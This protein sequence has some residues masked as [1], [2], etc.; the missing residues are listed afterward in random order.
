MDTLIQ[1]ILDPRKEE[2][3]GDVPFELRAYDTIFTF[4]LDILREDIEFLEK[5]YEL[6]R[7]NFENRKINPTISL[8]KLGVI[9]K[10]LKEFSA[11]VTGLDKSIDQIIEDDEDLSRMELSRHFKNPS[12]YE[13][14]ILGKPSADMDILIEYCDRELDGLTSRIKQLDDDI[15]ATERLFTLRIGIIRN[16]ILQVDLYASMIQLGIG[17]GTCL[18]GIFGMNLLSKLEERDNMFNAISFVVAILVGLSSI[19]IGWLR[20]GVGI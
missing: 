1:Y 8:T 7:K 13:K 16:K 6:L 11:R 2:K 10:K 3:E 17:F 18:S 12:L 15:K 4:T 5:E 19:A 14:Q 20:W 9:E